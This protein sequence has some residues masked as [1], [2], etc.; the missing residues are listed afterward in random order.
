M[1][2]VVLNSETPLTLPPNQI[3]IKEKDVRSSLAKRNL[4]AVNFTI[5]T[6]KVLLM[7]IEPIFMSSKSLALTASF[8]IF[9][10][11]NKEIGCQ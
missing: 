11:I 8:V 6:V 1:L 9:S 2:A 10:R 3:W 5:T 7:K 4:V